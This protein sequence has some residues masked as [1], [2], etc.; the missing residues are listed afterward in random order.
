METSR[1]KGQWKD[2]RQEGSERAR[3]HRPGLRRL[4]EGKVVRARGHVGTQF[5]GGER[6]RQVIWR[7]DQHGKRD[8]QGASALHHARFLRKAPRTDRGYSHRRLVYS[9]HEERRSTR[10]Q[11][12]DRRCQGVEEGRPRG[13]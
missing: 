5:G 11:R 8:P 1:A 9:G 13:S 7:A 12:L 4:G 2:R 10:V 3:S 6:R